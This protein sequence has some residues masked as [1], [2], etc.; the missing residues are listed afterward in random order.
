MPTRKW[1]IAIDWFIIVVVSIVTVGWAVKGW[2]DVMEI[3]EHGSGVYQKEMPQIRLDVEGLK[4]G[5]RDISNKIND[6][7]HKLDKCILGK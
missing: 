4:E 6:I 7:D 5:Q 2:H 1:G 3:N